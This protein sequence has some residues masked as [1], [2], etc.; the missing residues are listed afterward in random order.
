LKAVASVW[1]SSSVFATG[2]RAEKSPASILPAALTSSPTGLTSRSAS[3]SAVNVES[4][5]MINEPRSSAALNR[6]WFARDR[7]SSA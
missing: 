3:L 4:A 7:F 6:S 1:T 2:T 5:T